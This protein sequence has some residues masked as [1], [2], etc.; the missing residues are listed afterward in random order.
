[1]NQARFTF[2]RSQYRADFAAWLMSNQAIWLRFCM[3][4]NRVWDRGRRHY[5][6]RTI[7]EYMRH[8]TALTDTTVEVKITNNFC[9]DMARLF[10]ATYPERA[11]LFE[12]R[13]MPGSARA[14]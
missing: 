2:D 7:L 6:A 10:A 1:M 4:A 9:P 12:F 14:A 11:G 13:V 5:S 8:E 3:E